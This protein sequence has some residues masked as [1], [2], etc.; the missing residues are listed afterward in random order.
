DLAVV[1]DEATPVGE[2]MRIVRSTAGPLLVEARLFDAYRGPQIGAG[3]VSYA[4]AL[5]FQ[6]ETAAD[7]KGVDRAMGRLRGALEHH[8]AAQLR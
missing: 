1:V 7:E 4:I 6:P 8:L 2:L 5:R 3:K